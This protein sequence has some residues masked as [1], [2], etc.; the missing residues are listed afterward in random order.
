MNTGQFRI[1]GRDGDVGHDWDANDPASVQ[2]AEQ[3]FNAFIKRGGMAFRTGKENEQIRAFEK[4]AT[5][6][7]L[8]PQ[9][10][11]GR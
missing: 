3:R 10:A 6:I 1:M 7:I 5:E 4:D 8:V 2:E 11:G 9:I